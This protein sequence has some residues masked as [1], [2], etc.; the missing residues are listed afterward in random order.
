MSHES[1]VEH[2]FTIFCGTEYKLTWT[3]DEDDAYPG[4]DNTEYNVSITYTGENNEFEL[5][6]FGSEDC[7]ENIHYA[8][9]RYVDQEFPSYNGKETL[10]LWGKTDTEHVYTNFVMFNEHYDPSGE[11]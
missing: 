6:V 5:T 10:Y 3:Y 1:E 8:K 4:E 11:I 7:R 2:Q 9:T